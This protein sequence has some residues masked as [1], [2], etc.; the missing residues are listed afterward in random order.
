MTGTASE[1]DEPGSDLAVVADAARKIN[2]GE[3]VDWALLD[4]LSANNAVRATL[5]ALHD[6]QEIAIF[7]RGWLV[8]EQ[9]AT[10]SELPAWGPLIVMEEVGRGSFGRVYR[11]RDPR[12]DR[13]VALKILETRSDSPRGQSLVDEGRH[14]ARLRHPNIVSIYGAD[15]IDGRIGF[16]MELING[17]SLAAIIQTQGPFSPDEAALICRDVCRALAAVHAGG[18]VH[19][20]IKAQNVIRERGGRIVLM[21]FG[22][23]RLVD[24]IESAA[25]AGTPL[26]LAPEVLDGGTPTPQSD[27]YSVGVLLHF[28]VTGAFPVRARSLD[29]LREA[30]RTR[31]PA[32]L[33]DVRPGLSERFYQ[34]VEHALASDPAHRIRSAGEFESQLSLTLELGDAGS[35]SAVR[36]WPAAAGVATVAAVV[37]VCWAYWSRS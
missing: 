4:S 26:Y 28:L 34:V 1:Q 21:D 37:A 6:L 24:I 30:H 8:S 3:S 14:L 29:E 11:A 13:D 7:H 22:A 32:Q 18:V 27:L 12:L 10:G 2:A 15:R 31:M 35:S 23:G 9:P 19:R 5:R 16:E 25:L 33:R 17:R 36:G 20:D